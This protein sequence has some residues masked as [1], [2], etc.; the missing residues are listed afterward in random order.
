MP[1]PPPLSEPAIVTHMGTN[2]ALPFDVVRE[3]L[4][5]WSIITSLIP[6]GKMRRHEPVWSLNSDEGNPRLRRVKL[7]SLRRYYPDQV[8]WVNAISVSQPFV[9][10]HRT[11]NC[12]ALFLILLRRHPNEFCVFRHRLEVEAGQAMEKCSFKEN[13]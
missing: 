12:L 6:N 7:R 2:A 9:S 11:E 4:F 1:A 8:Q 3:K 13:P 10:Q 5:F